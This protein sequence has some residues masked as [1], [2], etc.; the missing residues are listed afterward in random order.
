M[1]RDKSSWQPLQKRQRATKQNK[2]PIPL[3]TEKAYQQDNAIPS[4]VQQSLLNVFRDACNKGSPAEIEDILQEVKGHLFNRDF[5]TAFG[6]DEY[7][8]AYAARWSPS[9]ALG[10]AQIFSDF[11]LNLDSTSDSSK[12]LNILC[13]GGGAGAEVVGLAGWY[14][15]LRDDKSSSEDKPQP[16]ISKL[17]IFGVDVANW[18]TVMQDLHQG[19]ITPPFLSKY[20]SAAAK[21]ANNAVL[22]SEVFNVRFKQ[23]DLLDTDAAGVKD[24]LA[25]SDI[26]T[27]M[28]TLNELYS[29]SVA[30]TQ[31]LL[32]ALTASMRPGSLLLVVD[33]PGS[34][35]TVTLN[36]ASQKYPM[37]WLLDHTLI[38]PKKDAAKGT[39]AQWNKLLSDESRWFRLPDEDLRYPID[40]ENMRYQIHLYQR[41]DGK[42]EPLQEQQ[43]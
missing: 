14:K 36:G 18:D 1:P 9:R 40:L 3:P 42:Q 17:D 30:K 20:A 32:Y 43:K 31:R 38:S 41:H 37:Q 28:F 39:P 16:N 29:T 23:Q 12:P 24:L 6:K 7:L 35:S 15:H 27:I 5:A 22:P 10:Y 13:L 25:N 26:V 2:G 8:Q 21:A 19:V 33:S 11:K 34:Y 4:S